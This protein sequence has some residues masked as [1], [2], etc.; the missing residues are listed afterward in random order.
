MCHNDNI[1]DKDSNNLTY[2]AQ[3]QGNFKLKAWAVASCTQMD[4]VS[5]RP[6]Q[7]ESEI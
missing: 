6:T 4:H 7:Q 5:K 2:N 3:Y 1:H